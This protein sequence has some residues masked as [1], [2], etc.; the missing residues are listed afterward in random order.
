VTAPP[1]KQPEAFR[2][3][4]AELADAPALAE[5][6]VSGWRS[7]YRG[8]V[9]D[10]VLDG[11]SIV[12]HTREWQRHFTAPAEDVG[13]VLVVEEGDVLGFALVSP[14]PDRDLDP[15]AVLELVA[16]YVHPTC[17]GRGLGRRLVEA[18]AAEARGRGGGSLSLWVLE[19]NR[20]AR[21][22]YEHLGFMPD[23][24]RELRHVAGVD[25][26]TLRYRL[27]VLPEPAEGYPA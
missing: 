3:R 5:I 23:G 1:I 20:R 8:M 19:G 18:C 16:L 9:P 6:H 22:V 25:L 4:V 12:R 14:S 24:A 17:W 2:V 21:S 26:P 11:L 10:H 15:R 27:S 13:R 7:A